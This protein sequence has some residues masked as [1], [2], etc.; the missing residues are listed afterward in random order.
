MNQYPSNTPESKGT[1]DGITAAETKS[2]FTMMDDIKAN[3]FE[4]E[5]IEETV[6]AKTD[7]ILVGTRDNI[8]LQTIDLQTIAGELPKWYLLERLLSSSQFRRRIVYSAVQALRA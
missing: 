7:D 3:D 2:L 1:K 4:E 6:F 8:D 5:S